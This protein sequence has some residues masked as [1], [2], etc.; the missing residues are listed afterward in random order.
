MW[1][2][3]MPS[4]RQCGGAGPRG[5]GGVGEDERV[6]DR[7]HLL[8]WAAGMRPRRR[9]DK[10]RMWLDLWRRDEV[11]SLKVQDYICCIKSNDFGE[12]KMSKRL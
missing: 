9:I 1:L 8:H 4:F 5:R 7:W 3:I 12:Y 2:S 11:L 10:E 6:G